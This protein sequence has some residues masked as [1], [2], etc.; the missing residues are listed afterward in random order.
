MIPFFGGRGTMPDDLDHH[1][2]EMTQTD[3][4]LTSALKALIEI[5]LSS[6]IAKPKTFDVYLGPIIQTYNAQG[7]L[8]AAEL[9]RLLLV[10]ANE[11][12]RVANR[13]IRRRLREG[14]VSGSA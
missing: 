14:P 4:A 12:A 3:L 5:F 11:P 7:D 1:S 9:L 13:E 10:Y 6:G 8:K 2:D